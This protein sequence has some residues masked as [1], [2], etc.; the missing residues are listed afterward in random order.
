MKCTVD[1]VE[2]KRDCGCF[3]YFKYDPVYLIYALLYLD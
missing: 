3:S 1:N 2:F